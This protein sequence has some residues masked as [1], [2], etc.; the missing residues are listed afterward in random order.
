MAGCGADLCC[1]PL[2]EGYVTGGLT[3]E[4]VRPV[5]MSPSGTMVESR[6][7]GELSAKRFERLE[8]ARGFELVTGRGWVKN[9]SDVGRGAWLY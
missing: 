1:D 6:E 3:A 4:V 7:E 9:G 5:A 8:G 2:I